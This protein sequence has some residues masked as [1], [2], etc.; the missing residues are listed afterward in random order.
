MNELRLKDYEK[1]REDIH[2][3]HKKEY[4][5]LE[6]ELI[7]SDMSL[8]DLSVVLGRTAKAIAEARKNFKRRLLNEK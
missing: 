8:A 2:F 7:L 1:Y 3:N 4:T 5:T 6:V